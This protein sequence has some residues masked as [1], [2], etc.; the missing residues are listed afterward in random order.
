MSIKGTY[1][2]YNL[3]SRQRKQFRFEKLYF[4]LLPVTVRY[5]INMKILYTSVHFDEL[6]LLIELND[7]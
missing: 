3:F 6:T 7:L 1:T 4:T 5:G 2:Y